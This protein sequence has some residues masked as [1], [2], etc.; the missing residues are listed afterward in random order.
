MVL[1]CSKKLSALLKGITPKHKGYFYCL[2]YLHCFRTKN[3]LELRKIVC[4]NRDFCNVFFVPLRTKILEFNQYQKSYKPPFIIYADPECIIEKIVRC[5]NDP[6]ISSATKAN[7][8]IPPGFAMS[9]ISSFKNVEN[10]HDVYKG[11]DYMKKLCKSLREH[12]IKIISFFK[13]TK[14]QNCY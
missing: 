9:T 4:E 11:K 6:K 13:T 7:E 1:S 12:A 10:K 8:H 3:K 14:K 2:N 5:K